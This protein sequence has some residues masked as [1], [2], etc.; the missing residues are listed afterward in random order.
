VEV[1]SRPVE[2]NYLDHRI[3][4]PT[5]TLTLQDPALEMAA[6]EIWE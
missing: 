2:G 5:E 3:V 1:Y 6:G 4:G